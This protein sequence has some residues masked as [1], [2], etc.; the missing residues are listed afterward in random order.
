MKTAGGRVIDAVN[1]WP[2]AETRR[3]AAEPDRGY[4][5]TLSALILKGTA[6]HVF[7]A[8]DSRIYRVAGR[9][10]EQLTEDHRV[11]ASSEQSYLVSS[12]FRHIREILPLC[13]LLLH[14]TIRRSIFPQTVT[15]GWSSTERMS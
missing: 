11:H 1:S 6:G 15:G 12:S 8:D 4:V 13:R 7:H 9:S 14:C 2:H 5:C 10:L 3:G